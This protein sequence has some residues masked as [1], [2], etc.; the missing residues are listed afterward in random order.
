M[1]ITKEEEKCVIDDFEEAFAI[2]F[3]S[4][5][6]NRDHTLIT[7][8]LVRRYGLDEYKRLV[9]EHFK[10]RNPHPKEVKFSE[11]EKNEIV[12]DF[13]NHDFSVKKLGIKYKHGCEI[14]V[15]FLTEKMGEDE[16]KKYVKKHRG[17]TFLELNKYKRVEISKEEGGGHNS[18]IFKT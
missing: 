10:I 13:A 6:Y 2:T 4:K 15:R 18:R 17:N 8:I 12:D 16:Y 9:A 5:K 3:L 11:K 1:D 7:K 14:M